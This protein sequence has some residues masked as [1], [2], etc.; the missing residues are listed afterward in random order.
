MVLALAE[1]VRPNPQTTQCPVPAAQMWRVS[2]APGCARS[3]GARAN[4]K[5][6]S[7]RLSQAPLRS[8]TRRTVALRWPG[9]G[10]PPGWGAACKRAD[11]TVG[12]EFASTDSGLRKGENSSKPRACV[13]IR[14]LCG[15]TCSGDEHVL[16]SRPFLSVT[17]HTPFLWQETLFS[18]FQHKR[19]RKTCNIPTGL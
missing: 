15:C 19:F 3:D 18:E 9:R 14:L 8:K 1:A 11:S 10:V 17:G 12:V 16:F 13:H 6:A 4:Y 2:G 5:N 7:L